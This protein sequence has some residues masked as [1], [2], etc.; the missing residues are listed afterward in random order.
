VA[1][2]TR[3]SG[4]LTRASSPLAGA[5]AVAAPSR[6]RTEEMLGPA[7]LQLST[8]PVGRGE[9]VHSGG[10]R[11][12]GSSGC[13]GGC[14]GGYSTPR[15]S[16]TARPCRAGL[17]GRALWMPLLTPVTSAV[18]FALAEAT[19][20]LLGIAETGEP[21]ST[22]E[23]L[24]LRSAGVV[25]LV[26][27]PS[28]QIAGVIW[29]AG[30]ARRTASAGRRAPRG[31]RGRSSRLRPRAVR[32]KRG[33]GAADAVAPAL[34]G[35]VPRRSR[36]GGSYRGRVR[37]SL[38]PSCQPSRWKRSTGGNGCGRHA[39]TTSRT[40]P[41]TTA[42]AARARIR[43][44]PRSPVRAIVGEPGD[45]AAAPRRGHSDPALRRPGRPVT[46]G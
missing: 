4:R 43:A 11:A 5:H 29:A 21:S 14:P 24:V 31:A 1:D 30:V 18:T 22:V 8:S 23:W 37:V 40:T 25:G 42:A 9:Q 15:R 7:E 6:L 36:H 3:V 19:N 17:W 34:P 10:L 46:E 16:R 41:S 38:T 27:I 45:S 13:C 2:D 44:C 28:P 12:C 32:E 35:F 26:L 39:Q 20:W 33:C